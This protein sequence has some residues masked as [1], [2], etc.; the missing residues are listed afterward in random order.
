[1]YPIANDGIKSAR[2]QG[3]SSPRRRCSTGRPSWDPHADRNRSFWHGERARETHRVRSRAAREGRHG[4]LAEVWVCVDLLHGFRL[5]HR[6]VARAAA[7]SQWET[8][9]EHALLLSLIIPRDCAFAVRVETRWENGHAELRRDLWEF[10]T[11]GTFKPSPLSHGSHW[12]DRDAK[13]FSRGGTHENETHPARFRI[14][15]VL[16]SAGST[17]QS[18]ESSSVSDFGACP[19]V[20]S[21]QPDVRNGKPENGR[22][23]HHGR[24]LILRESNGEESQNSKCPVLLGCQHQ[25]RRRQRE[26]RAG[27]VGTRAGAIDEARRAGDTRDR[28]GGPERRRGEARQGRRGVEGGGDASSPCW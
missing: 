6:A 5:R 11:F 1:M 7:G 17:S 21:A 14:D 26:A 13:I 19:F 18:R 22:T 16:T 8:D 9:V 20:I 15:F 24:R 12:V 10:T 28:G 27:A 23:R 2:N 3:T 25:E 4:H